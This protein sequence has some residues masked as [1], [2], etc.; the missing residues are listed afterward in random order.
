M[1]AGGVSVGIYATNETEACRYISQHSQAKVVVV[2]GLAQLQKYYAI[3]KNLKP[4]LQALVVYGLY[5]NDD[6][7]KKATIPDSVKAQCGGIPVYTFD[8]FCALGNPTN[9]KDKDEQLKAMLAQRTEAWQPGHTCS[10]IYTSGTTGPPKAVMITHDNITWQAKTVSHLAVSHAG[11]LSERDC[12]VSYLPLSH[13]AAQLLDI[14]LPIQTGMQIY[15]AQPDALKGSL[16]PLLL[17]VRPTVFF[18]V[19]RVWEKF[20]GTCHSACGWQAMRERT[21]GHQ[22]FGIMLSL[23]WRLCL[24]SLTPGCW[25]LCSTP[26]YYGQKNCKWCPNPR[27]VL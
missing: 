20:Y 8:E 19:P 18:G 26:Y 15:F 4:Q 7:D 16:G 22:V 21:D 5:N 3:A 2:H 11:E 14:Y 23:S 24:V 6:N 17:E 10:L 13:I 12:M 27:L 9:D 1:A 25:F